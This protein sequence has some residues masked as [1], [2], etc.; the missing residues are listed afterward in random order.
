MSL[1]KSIRKSIAALV[2]I[3]LVNSNC[4]LC[5]IGLSK[6]IAQDVKEPDIKL[7]IA[8]NQYVQFKEEIE[9]ED[10]EEGEEKAEPHYNY[11][12]AVQTKLEVEIEEQET[13][14]PIIKTELM[15]FLPSL[16]GYFPQR[17][18]VVD[19]DTLL[20]TGEENSK[21]INQNYDSNSGLLSV[22]YENEE[23]YSNYNE[24]SKDEFEIIYI[25]PAEAYTGNEE[26]ITLS[27]TVNAKITFET[28]DLE[29]VSELTRTIERKR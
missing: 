24:E 26:E 28:E 3:L 18:N 27:Y 7:N 1:K 14:L 4:Y 9:V 11:G 6:V 2:A 10:K 12:V 20:S 29:L 23:A 21:K 8:N 16:N 15:V 19:S 25:Y 22:S 13:N 17:A 5:G